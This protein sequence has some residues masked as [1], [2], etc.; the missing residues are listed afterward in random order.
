[1]EEE[2]EEEEEEDWMARLTPRQVR[3][4]FV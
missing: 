4:S 1:M 3:S 2:E